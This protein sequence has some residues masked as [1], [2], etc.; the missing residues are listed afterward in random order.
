[1]SAFGGEADVTFF[2]SPLSRSPLVALGSTTAKLLNAF[3]NQ[4]ETFRRL[5]NGSS[6]FVRVE[7]V[8]INEGGQADRW[9]CQSMQFDAK[10]GQRRYF[11]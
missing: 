6:Q 9:K 1:M 8:H 3:A 11:R 7:H 4:M 2:E 10:L 5:R